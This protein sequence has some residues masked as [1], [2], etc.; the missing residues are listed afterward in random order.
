MSDKKNDELGPL[1]KFLFLLVFFAS[2]GGWV[3]YYWVHYVFHLELPQSQ[4][5]VYCVLG[6]LAGKYG[7]RAGFIIWILYLVGALPPF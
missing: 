3:A 2:V 6:L 7:I 5:W 1:W 4:Y